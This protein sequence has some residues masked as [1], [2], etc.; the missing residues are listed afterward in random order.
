MFETDERQGTT[1]LGADGWFDP[2]ALSLL[3]THERIAARRRMTSGELWRIAKYERR[4]ARCL[5]PQE[6]LAL[7]DAK[8]GI[9]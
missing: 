9:I 3:L 7:A 5:T 1:T 4:L 8:L 2:D 6:E